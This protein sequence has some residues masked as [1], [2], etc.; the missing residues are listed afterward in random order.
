MAR[1]L[2]P[3]LPAMKAVGLRE[4]ASYLAGDRGLAEAIELARRETR[5]YA[6]R[7]STWLRNQVAD[8]PRIASLDSDEQWGDLTRLAGRSLV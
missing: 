4:L 6:K 8:W 1:G 5:R 2:D 7:Q 3:E